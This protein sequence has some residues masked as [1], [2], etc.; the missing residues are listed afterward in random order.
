M[1]KRKACM[2]L[3]LY[4]FANCKPFPILSLSW[5]WQPQFGGCFAVATAKARIR[6]Q[7]LRFEYCHHCLL[8]LR[9]H[10]SL[11]RQGMASLTSH[12]MPYKKNNA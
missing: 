1:K 10:G 6:M 9:N 8:T 5:L 3:N 4:V 12:D 7:A 11:K 2:L